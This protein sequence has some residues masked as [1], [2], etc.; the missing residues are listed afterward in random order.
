MS[1]PCAGVKQIACCEFGVVVLTQGGQVYQQTHGNNGPRLKKCFIL[2]DAFIQ[3]DV[4]I[5]KIAAHPE[6][7]STPVL[8]P[9]LLT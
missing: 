5:K 4:T 7:R 6:G 9:Y 8:S 1:G 2:L 3:D